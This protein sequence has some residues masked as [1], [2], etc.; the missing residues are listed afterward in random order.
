MKPV[1]CVVER[2]YRRAETCFAEHPLVELVAAPQGEAALAEAVRRR[3]ALGV[4]LAT[5]RYSGALY[6]ALPR[7]GIIARFGVGHDGVDK[8]R[9]TAAGVVVTNTPGVLDDSV[10]ELAIWLMGALA[11][12]IGELDA[13]IKTGRWQRR[14]G[15]E[16]RGKTLLVL[17]CG[18]IGRKVA[19]IAAGGLGMTVIGY[20]VADLDAQMLAEECGISRFY[21]DGLD[22]VLGRA[23]VVSIHLP[24]NEAT[25]DYVNE[26]FLQQMKSTAY[27]IN[28]AR[29]A[30]VDEIALYDALVSGTIAAAALDVFKTEPY[31]PAAPDKD[32]RTLSNIIMT[33]H[34]AS[35]TVEADE[36]MARRVL[37]NIEALVQRRYDQLD[38]VN[39]DVLPT[40][41]AGND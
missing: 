3:G 9:A 40:I 28:T 41:S 27:L 34:V 13:G 4:V 10:A 11:R 1:I 23:D 26:S 16:L 30:V 22:A 2:I 7:G 15:S 24:A 21:R 25:R 38:C 33:P 5:D 31:E 20:D 37:A 14:S 39:R 29:G 36:R 6:E 17:G 32:L 8:A 12:R 35:S 18:H 19:G